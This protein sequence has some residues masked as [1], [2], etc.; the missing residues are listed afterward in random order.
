MKIAVACD[1]GGFDLK[2]PVKAVLAGLGHEVLD[3]GAHELDPQDDFPDFARYIGQ[4]LQHKQAERG[5][6]LC[7]S[8]VGAAIAAT[9]MTGV[10][11][12]V[13]HDVYSARQGVEHDD[14]NVLCLGARIVGSRLAEELVKAFASASFDPGERFQRR[15]EKVLALEA[16]H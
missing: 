8:G 1:H 9:K 4:A 3:L 13:C 2:E 10:R 12:S 7:G 15:L 6:L 16:H 14:M 11:A 5:V